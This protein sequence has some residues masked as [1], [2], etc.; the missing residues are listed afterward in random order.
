MKGGAGVCGHALQVEHTLD[1]IAWCI[2]I[3]ADLLS[4][5][6]TYGKFF[7]FPGP[8]PSPLRKE[9]IR[10]APQG[11]FCGMS[12]STQVSIIK[13]WRVGNKP[14]KFIYLCSEVASPRPR[15][16]SLLILD[17]YCLSLFQIVSFSLCPYMREKKKIPFPC[18]RKGHCPGAGG[19]MHRYA[20]SCD[21][22]SPY[23]SC[24]FSGPVPG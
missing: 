22:G 19:V 7:S 21:A 20:L 6:W 3:R 8:Q 11:V 16:I 17:E 9:M 14:Q 13:Y 12:R 18:Y 10:H 15:C 4:L 2:E 24:S 23:W 5:K 1:Q